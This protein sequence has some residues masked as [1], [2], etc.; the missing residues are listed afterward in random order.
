MIGS[1]SILQ[2]FVLTLQKYVIGLWARSSFERLYDQLLHHVRVTNSKPIHRRKSHP[3]Q[4]P[5]ISSSSRR[6]RR[7]NSSSSSSWCCRRRRRLDN[8]RQSKTTHYNSD[9]L[10]A[11]QKNLALSLFLVPSW[12]DFKCVCLEFSVRM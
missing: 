8:K 10:I 3:Q 11:I 9:L 6:R 4:G 1:T 7:S 5:I 2:T 12:K